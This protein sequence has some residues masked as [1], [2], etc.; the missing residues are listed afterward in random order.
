MRKLFGIAKLIFCVMFLLLTI[1]TVN[2]YSNFNEREEVDS[3]P[4]LNKPS[5]YAIVACIYLL[6]SICLGYSGITELRQEPVKKIVL[7][8]GIA[9]G[10]AFILNTYLFYSTSNLILSFFILAITIRDLVLVNRKIN[11]ESNAK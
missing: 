7:W 9:L 5:T 11:Y 1:A 4:L 8:L 3:L 2:Y 6:Y 10:L